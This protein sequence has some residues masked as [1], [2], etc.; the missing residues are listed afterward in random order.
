MK[1]NLVLLL[2][3][4]KSKLKRL[5]LKQMTHK[6]T[7]LQTQVQILEQMLKSDNIL[8]WILC[9]NFKQPP[10]LIF[11]QKLK[12]NLPSIWKLKWLSNQTW[13]LSQKVRTKTTMSR[14]QKPIRNK[15]LR[16]LPIKKINLLLLSIVKI[17]LKLKRKLRVPREILPRNWNK[18]LFK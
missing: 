4:L 18:I 17:K 10:R 5:L 9:S 11:Q 13:N 16:L 1:L 7:N 12:E 8:N 14:P 3:K 15:E 2:R 6:R